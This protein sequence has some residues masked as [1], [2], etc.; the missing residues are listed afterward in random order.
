[1]PIVTGQ[2]DVIAEFGDAK[3]RRVVASVW[4]A[5]PYEV[6]A[7]SCNGDAQGHECS[8]RQD[9]LIEDGDT[10]ASLDA[11]IEFAVE[12]VAEHEERTPSR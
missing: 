3:E 11:A 1:M 7:V 4:P 10:W 9:I 2:F 6:Y 5:G 12:H 8:S